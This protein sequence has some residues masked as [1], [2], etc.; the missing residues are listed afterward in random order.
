MEPSICVV[1]EKPIVDPDDVVFAAH[2]HMNMHRG[3]DVLGRE[4]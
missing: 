2:Y 3:C 1:C 4:E